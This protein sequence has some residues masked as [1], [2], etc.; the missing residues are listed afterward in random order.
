M[1]K[2]MEVHCI[3]IHHKLQTEKGILL[4]GHTMPAS[5]TAILL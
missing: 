1:L 3:G 4:N 2:A 5:D